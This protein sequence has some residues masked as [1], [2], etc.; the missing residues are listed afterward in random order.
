MKW[1]SH[2]KILRPIHCVVSVRAQREAVIKHLEY[3]Q[4]NDLPEIEDGN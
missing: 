3:L 1:N 2:Y 4:S